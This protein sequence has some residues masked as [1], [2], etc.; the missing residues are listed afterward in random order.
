MPVDN[1]I[2]ANLVTAE[3]ELIK[4]SK[5]EHDDLFWAIGGAGPNFGIVTSVIMKAYPRANAMIWVAQLAFSGDKL[6]EYLD[7][8]NNLELSEK[9]IVN[10]G[11][12]YV[13]LATDPYIVSSLVYLD[14][15]ADAAEAA[16]KPLLGLGPD[17]KTTEIT[18]YS[19]LNDGSD[20]FCELDGSKPT[21]QVGLKTLDYP[22]WQKIYDELADFVSATNQTS[23]RV[24]VETYSTKVLREIGS[25]GASYPHRAINYYAF[26]QPVYN[27]PALDSTAEEF[28]A[29]VRDLWRSTD[30][31][32]KPRT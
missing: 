5:S 30:G 31:F 12:T 27:N 25:D 19:H 9:M 3:G 16:F 23:S 17:Q 8:M 21:W 7:V 28:G 14:D 18:E 32:D 22:T 11:L 6:E 15:D 1:I 2:S 26:V 20:P 13:P 10:W 4:V 24:F 29:K